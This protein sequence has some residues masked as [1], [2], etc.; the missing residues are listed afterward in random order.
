MSAIATSEATTSTG[1]RTSWSGTSST[2]AT[3]PA[4]RRPRT[5]SRRVAACISSGSLKPSLP[6]PCRPGGRCRSAS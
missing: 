5:S 4:S 2:G 1:P 6:S 3:S